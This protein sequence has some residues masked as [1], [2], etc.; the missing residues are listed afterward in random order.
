MK[1]VFTG[2][3]TGGHFYPIIAVA[4]K[5]NQIID[6]ENII[7]AKLY[8]FSSDPY[9]KELLF[10]N[11]LIYEEVKTGKLR[12]YFSFKN[13]V[14]IFKIFFGTINAIF[15]IFSIYPDVI[16]GKG[17]Y[18][19]FPVLFA[20]RILNIPIIIHESDSAPGRVNKW[21]GSFA[22]KIAISFPE[23]AQCFIK[24][25]D[26][27]D[28]KQS[29]SLN[30]IACTGQPM[31]TGLEYPE[32]HE[33]SFEY[34]KLESDLPVILV[35]GGSLGAELINNT[36]LD[37]LP[38]LLKNYQII[39]QTGIKNFQS[40]TQRAE[41]VINQNPD[42][43]LTPQESINYKSRYTP[44]PFLNLLKI[45][46]AAGAA[47][48]IISRAGSSLFEF[49][50]WGIPS[51]LIPITN[52]NDDHQRKNAFNY[53][54]AGACSVIEEAN[55]TAN[56]LIAEIERITNN[57]TSLEKMSKNAKAFYK[58][59]AAQKIAQALMDIALSHEN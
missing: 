8:Y 40:V 10:E 5:V 4:Q 52:S 47:T 2:G 56:I 46:M 22:K 19:S 7:G 34:F 35:L 20:A 24:N 11:R 9:D 45:K 44:I 36:V 57:K 55:L 26:A 49:A 25:N 51:I 21:A 33:Q 58:P 28:N 27:K 37:G 32:N 50:A 23:T 15:K 29:P 30:K 59:N 54:R 13:F 17:G 16:F 31:R 1:I 39:H 42:P 12:T 14:D 38:R 6:R 53:A 43:S 48:I 41:V 18:D 3:G